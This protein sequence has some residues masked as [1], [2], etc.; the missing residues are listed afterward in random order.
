MKHFGDIAFTDQVKAEQ[1]ARGSREMYEGMVARPA[2]EGFSEREAA[3]I[4]MRDS[5]YMC[6]KTAGLISSIA[7]ARAGS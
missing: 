4:T 6:P 5:F 2:P 3:F 7:A 1:H